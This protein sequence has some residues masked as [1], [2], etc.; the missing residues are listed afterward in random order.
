MQRLTEK[1]VLQ[2]L[3]D[4]RFLRDALCGKG[5]PTGKAGSKTT[6]LARAFADL[7]N[8]LQ[9]RSTTYCAQALDP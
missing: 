9:V 4:A 3:F 8:N 7:E 2:L 5:V 1:G 6:E